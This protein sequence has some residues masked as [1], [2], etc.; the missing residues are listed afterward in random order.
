M[1]QMKWFLMVL[2]FVLS[3]C[4]SMVL[5]CGDDDDDDSGDDDDN[6]DDDDSG[7]DDDDSVDWGDWWPPADGSSYLY[8]ASEWQG[9]AYDLMLEVLGDDV[10]N[11]QTYTKVQLGNFTD[12]DIIGFHLWLDLSTPGQIGFAGSQI[13]WAAKD[14]SDSP[15]GIFELDAPVYIYLNP[16]L[17]DPQTDSTSGTWTVWGNPGT[18]DITLTS[19]TLDKNASVTVPYG[20]IDGCWEIQVDAVEEF[21]LWD[22]YNGSATIYFHKDLG[23]VK[24]GGERLMGFFLELKDVL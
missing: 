11:S 19:T 7:D 5:G 22:T 8:E 16:T 24:I 6:G 14:K 4:L 15:G 18:V 17:N 2:V 20:T 13:Y 1:H 10:L 21:E 9:G 23:F 12:I 3:I